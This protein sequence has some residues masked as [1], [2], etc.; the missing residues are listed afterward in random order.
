MGTG[1]R[2]DRRAA[3]SSPGER[4]GNRSHMQRGGDGARR[5]G[6]QGQATQEG[7]AAP[8]EA[9]F[10]THMLEDGTDIRVIQLLLPQGHCT[11]TALLGHEAPDVGAELLSEVALRG[12]ALHVGTVEPAHV[13]GREHEAS[14][15][16]VLPGEAR[17]SH[18]P[19]GSPPGALVGAVGGTSPQ[20]TS[21]RTIARRLAESNG[22]S[23]RWF[24]TASKNC[25]AVAVKAPPVSR[26]MRSAW[27]G[28]SLA[29]SA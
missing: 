1:C 29:S 27:S 16:Q 19:R 15:L 6:S 9:S 10:A 26:T 24:G 21:P 23:T 17:S 7:H 11:R 8:V 2:C 14:A 4:L 5:G 20:R 22:F 18:A 28:A 3:G 13:L 25:R 12:P